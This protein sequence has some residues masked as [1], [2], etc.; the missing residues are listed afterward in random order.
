VAAEEERCPPA[1]LAAVTALVTGAR[2]AAARAGDEAALAILDG[3]GRWVGIGQS[4]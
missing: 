1:A 3:F 4:T 2:T